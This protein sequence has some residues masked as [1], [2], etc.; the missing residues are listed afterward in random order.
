MGY[1]VSASGNFKAPNESYNNYYYNY[2]N[3]YLFLF[4]F[5]FP[6]LF[7]FTFISRTS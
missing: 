1:V 6:L 3:Y 5:L 7:F 4:F 2:N